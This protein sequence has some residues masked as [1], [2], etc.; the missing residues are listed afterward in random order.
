MKTLLI[1]LVSEQT[2]PN[3]QFINELGTTVAHYLFITTES[4]NK[5]EVP[6]WISTACKLSIEQ[7]SSI[8]VNQFSFEDIE[9][10]LENEFDFEVFEKVIV[11]LTGGTKIMILAAFEFFKKINAEI[12][13]VTGQNDEY[14]KISPGLR[15]KT[16]K[17][18]S[19]VNLQ[20]YLEAYGFKISK[21]TPSGISKE[22]TTIVFDSFVGNKFL[23]HTDVLNHLR[24]SYRS[25]SVGSISNVEG[26]NSFLNEIE[27][28][29]LID[30]KLNKYEVKYLTGEWFEEYIA[31][32][33]REELNLKDDELEVGLII[34]KKNKNGVLIA[35]EMDV[36]FVYKNTLYTIECKTSIYYNVTNQ[37]GVVEKINIL[38]DTIFK[39][40]SLKQ[41]FGLFVNTSIFVLDEINANINTERA[42]LSNINIIDKSKLLSGA[43]IKKLLNIK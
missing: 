20:Q 33:L 9:L 22:Q 7:I 1:S 36:L 30:N 42:E 12:Y 15:K 38:K 10:K 5:K 35:N 28:S 4:M 29:P 34:N 31:E 3:V 41:G 43:K 32:R 11:N 24:L 18:S 25:K 8:E 40:D 37:N 26:L 13:Y 27:Y 23:N 17:L 21:T 2:L 39:S 16:L 19:S 6:L 14:I